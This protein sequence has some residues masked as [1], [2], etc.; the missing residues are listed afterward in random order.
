MSD[1]A[2]RTCK[3][4]TREASRYTPDVPLP[5]GVCSHKQVNAQCDKGQDDWIHTD[6][7]S[8]YHGT[9]TGES[10]GCIHHEKKG[11]GQE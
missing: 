3:W 5:H 10:F 2:C 8:P 4:W 7:L 11:G 6:D 1:K 9:S